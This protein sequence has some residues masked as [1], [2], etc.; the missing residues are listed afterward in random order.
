MKMKTMLHMAAACVAV[1]M[2]V[3]CSS[4]NDI[5][6]PETPEPTT[7]ITK[8]I[9]LTAHQPGDE[10]GTRIGFDRNGKGYWHSSDEIAV[11]STGDKEFKKFKLSSGAGTGTGS[12]TGD[13]L[14]GVG[15]WAVY[16]CVA[17]SLH[18]EKITVGNRYY[19]FHFI[20]CVLPST[21]YYT[22][23]DK[24]F[25]P[26]YLNGNSFNMPMV[27]KVTENNEVSFT[28]MG[29]V[30][31]LQIDSMPATS[32]NVVVSS[33]SNKLCGLMRVVMTT[34]TMQMKT[35]SDSKTAGCKVTFNYSGATKG[36]P[37]VFYLPAAVGTYSL[38][39]TLS[40]G[41]KTY[42]VA[43]TV[44]ITRGRLQVVPVEIG[45]KGVYKDG[46]KFID[47]G[48]PSGLLWAE[49]N[50]GADS[51]LEDGCYFAWGET[52]PGTKSDYS[53]DTYTLGTS[54]DNLT[55]YNSND[56]KTV[57][58]KEDDAAYVNWGPSCRMPTNEEFKELLTYCK[59]EWTSKTA[60]DGSTVNGYTVSSTVNSNSIFL[61]A[62]GTR[63]EENYGHG[64]Y[65][66]YWSSTLYNDC[67][68]AY[69]LGFTSESSGRYASN[70]PNGHTVRPVA[71]P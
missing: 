2:A 66:Y 38:T 46:H 45:T 49:K 28:H 58:D 7:G 9:T 35:Y 26:G 12:F 32:G 8:T 41:S 18:T 51:P 57:L 19:S 44:E 50:V 25:F 62:S 11:Y 23:V 30:I 71:E 70:R 61:P 36:A 6:I 65:G 53:W 42:S 69:Y 15:T 40:G 31:C 59:W 68:Y 56:G 48:L 29:G 47:L 33:A 27:G 13:V 5:E 34:D 17:D 64:Q 43:N 37:G 16:P 60:S 24:T 1:A 21:Y 39:I 67:R 54:T 20:Y 63:D 22:S 14:G 10:Q 3:A 4:S 55:K 52:Y